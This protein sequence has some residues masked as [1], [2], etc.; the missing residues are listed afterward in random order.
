M[1]RMMQTCAP[2]GSASKQGEGLLH[3]MDECDEAGEPSSFS[4]QTTPAVQSR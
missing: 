3:D 2:Q 1:R 4:F